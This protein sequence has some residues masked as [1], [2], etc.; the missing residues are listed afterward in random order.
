MAT[1]YEQ[2]RFVVARLVGDNSAAEKVELDLPE[3]SIYSTN[4]PLTIK[5]S[6]C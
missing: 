2:V 3:T 5:N 4:L 6:C 1:G